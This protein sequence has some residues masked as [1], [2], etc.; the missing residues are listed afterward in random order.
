[1]H[2]IFIAHFAGSLRHGMV[3]GHYYLA[4]EW[5]L[6]GHQVTIIAA[7]FAHPRFNQPIQRRHLTVEVIDGI[8]YLWVPTPAYAPSGRFGRIRNILSFTL[9]TWLGSLPVDQADLIICSSHHPFP[10]HAAHRLARRFSARLVFEVRDLWPLTLIELGGI[11]P[12]NPFIRLMQ[13]SENYAYR[14]AD[15]VV[16]VLPSAKEYMIAHGMTPHKFIHI[17]NGVDLATEEQHEA[18]PE[19]IAA[20]LNE[21]RN[22]GK[23]IVG[24]AGRMG[25]A[26][27][28]HILLDAISLCPDLNVCAALLGDGSHKN[29]LQAQATRLGIEDRVFFFPS[30]PKTQVRDFLSR[31]DAA[32]IGLQRQPLFRFGTCPTK[33]NDYMLAALPIIHAGDT[34]YDIVTLSGAG[35]SCEPGNP[36]KLSQAIMLLKSYTA[37]QRREMGEK[38]YRWIRDNRNYRLLARNF[39]DAVTQ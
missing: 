23:F 9:R 3:Y 5:V 2:I 22:Q 20:I 18:V 24:Y 29:E 25:L 26:N 11:S 21:A 27:A 37:K 16:S 31:V 33:L 32:Y 7:S 13:L 28:L 19:E 12:S 10:I 34:P 17:P 15:H 35:L 38:G 14:H 6:T 30:V 1:M 4:R 8:R 39:L 36:Q